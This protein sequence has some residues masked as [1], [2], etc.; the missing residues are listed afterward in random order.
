MM[1]NPKHMHSLRLYLD[2]YCFHLL[3]VGE[4]GVRVNEVENLWFGLKTTP[5]H[6]PPLTQSSA[7]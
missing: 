6:P 3:N 7:I 4:S 1:I 2:D 5:L